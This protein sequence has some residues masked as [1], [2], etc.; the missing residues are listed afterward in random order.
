MSEAQASLFPISR[1]EMLR[2]VEREIAMRHRVYPL[3]VREGRLSQ[4]R[5]D[6]QMAVME[7]VAALLAEGLA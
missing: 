4:T 6:R 5:A 1:E 7:A 2:E 3:G